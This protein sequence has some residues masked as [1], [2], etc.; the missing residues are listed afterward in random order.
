MSPE[1][2]ERLRRNPNA[3]GEWLLE[4][5]VSDIDEGLKRAFQRV[6]GRLMPIE[7]RGHVLDRCIMHERP[8]KRILEKL[9]NLAALGKYVWGI[10]RN[11]G[12]EL[13]R[14]FLRGSAENVD[15]FDSLSELVNAAVAETR[16]EDQQE[17][18]NALLEKFRVAWKALDRA[19]RRVLRERIVAH[20]SYSGIAKLMTKDRAQAPTLGERSAITQEQI[21][22]V[23]HEGIRLIRKM[24]ES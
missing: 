20:R 19:Y 8:R 18:Y 9:E 17:I 11:V 24:M 3:L 12:R 7:Y 10:A 16:A 4:Q 21:E 15:D 5:F 6:N 14:E 1:E 2:L 22:F 13:T 23:Y